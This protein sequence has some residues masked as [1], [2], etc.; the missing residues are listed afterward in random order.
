MWYLLSKPVLV[1]HMEENENEKKKKKRALALKAF[2]VLSRP[3][4]VPLLL[5]SKHTRKLL[6]FFFFL[7]F[8]SEKSKKLCCS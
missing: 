6:N 7:P 4:F 8:F 1:A 5:I 2:A 3:P